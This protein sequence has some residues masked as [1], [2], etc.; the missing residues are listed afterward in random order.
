[1]VAWKRCNDA[2]DVVIDRIGFVSHHLWPLLGAIEF[3]ILCELWSS[4]W[5]DS[6][7]QV[8]GLI[9]LLIWENPINYLH[10]IKSWNNL[11]SSSIPP[12][13]LWKIFH[14]FPVIFLGQINVFCCFLYTYL[15]P[16]HYSTMS[17]NSM[18]LEYVYYVTWAPKQVRIYMY[19]SCIWV[20]LK[21][22]GGLIFLAIFT[23]NIVYLGIV[24]LKYDLL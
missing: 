22:L 18:T 13:H 14:N 24:H 17:V 2:W 12:L 7:I 8:W 16:W 10:G 23:W 4:N 5:G 19:Y 6:T 3:T 15:I 11:H 1:M 21:N 9:Y 20:T